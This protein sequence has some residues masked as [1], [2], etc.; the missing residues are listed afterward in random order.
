VKIKVT[1]D[2]I[3]RGKAFNGGYCPVALAIREQTQNVSVNN[4]EVRITGGCYHLPRSATRFITN[5]DRH[6]SVK[7]F[8]FLLK[9]AE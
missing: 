3:N 7:P 1:Q 2:H 9:E 8:M 6:K 4:R 5:F